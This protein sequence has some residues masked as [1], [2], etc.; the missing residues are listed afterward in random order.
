[1]AID[2]HLIEQEQKLRTA[3]SMRYLLRKTVTHEAALADP[4]GF[5]K[6][7]R[8]QSP[9]YLRR[10]VSAYEKSDLGEATSGELRAIATDKG[11]DPTNLTRHE[12]IMEI[13]RNASG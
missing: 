7:M 8:L 9:A 3:R 13:L 1:M 12:L 4:E 6:V 10:F 11:I 5:E 2:D